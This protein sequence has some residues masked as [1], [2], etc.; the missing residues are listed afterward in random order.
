VSTGYSPGSEYKACAF[1]CF[2]KSEQFAFGL[3]LGQLTDDNVAPTYLTARWQLI[4]VALSRSKEQP[5]VV[6]SREYLM[7]KEYLGDEEIET[8]K[9]LLRHA[10]IL[11]LN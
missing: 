5:I 7:N 3:L 6:G 4:N 8:F 10:R 9:R 2:L 11:R 1:F